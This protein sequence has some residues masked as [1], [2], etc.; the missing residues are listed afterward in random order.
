MNGDGRRHLHWPAARHVQIIHRMD[1][2]APRQRPGR[3]GGF[4]LI[5]LMIAVAVVAVLGALAYPSYM[6]S[7]RKSRRA[8]AVKAIAAVQQAQERSRGSWPSYCGDLTAAASTAACGLNQASSTPSGLYTLALANVTQTGYDV[9]ATASGSQVDDTR[10]AYL[11]VRMANGGNLLYDGGTS[12]PTFS[13]TALDPNK[14]W[15]K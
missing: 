11:G 4:T 3:Q 2:H 10:C 7:V 13:P 1:M 5:E 9:V 12:A 8:E 6:D 15:A 14:C